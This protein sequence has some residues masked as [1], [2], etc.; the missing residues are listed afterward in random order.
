LR[1]GRNPAAAAPVVSWINPRVT[2]YQGAF[3]HTIGYLN[4]SL[5]KLIGSPSFLAEFY[6]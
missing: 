6:D 2:S 4:T 5:D 3:L 1:T